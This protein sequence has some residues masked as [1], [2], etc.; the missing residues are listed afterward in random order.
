MRTIHVYYRYE[1]AGWW[2][3]SEDLPGWTA[4]GGSLAEVREM[5]RIGVDEF[6]GRDVVIEEEGVQVPLGS[7]AEGVP[8]RSKDTVMWRPLAGA[9]QVSLTGGELVI[10]IA[11][12]VVP[13]PPRRR[14][15]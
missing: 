15:A 11:S 9:A 12:L 10:L 1:P 2:A 3:A 13:G 14:V 5:V 6:A 7:A 8:V 4:V